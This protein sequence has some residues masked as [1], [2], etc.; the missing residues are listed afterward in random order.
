[1]IIKNG[2]LALFVYLLPLCLFAQ[3]KEYSEYEVKAAFLEKFTRFIDWP[4]EV[5]MEDANK[6]FVI[7]LIGDCPFKSIIIE[8]YSRQKIKG[9]KVEIR[10][11]ST[12][13]EIP[14][15]NLLFISKSG[16][17]RINQII[18]YTEN[19]PI[20]TISD[21]IEYAKRGVLITLFT[22]GNHI[23]FEINKNALQQSELYVS[24]LLLNLSKN[25]NTEEN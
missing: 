15:C 1:M 4:A 11:I 17:N 19:K 13:D 2:I 20:L 3:P 22:E 14:H 25:V 16:N 7:G 10:N 23:Y 18:S 8:M 12:L 21:E 9:K 5:N 24:T 6:P